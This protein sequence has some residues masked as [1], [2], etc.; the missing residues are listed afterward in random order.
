MN[1]RTLPL[2]LTLAALPLASLACQG[3]KG[4]ANEASVPKTGYEPTPVRPTARPA[5]IT[6]PAPGK[7]GQVKPGEPRG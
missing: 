7:P 4:N 1:R 5:I 6:E 3:D 2:L